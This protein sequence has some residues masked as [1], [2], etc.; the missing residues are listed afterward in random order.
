MTYF[1]F[2]VVLLILSFVGQEFL[3]AIEWAYYSRLLLVHTVFYSVAVTVP[4]PVMLLL[5]LLTGFVWDARYHIPVFPTGS[6]HSELGFGLTILLFGLMGSLIQGVRPLFRR[7]RW[8]LPVLFIGICTLAGLVIQYLII[9]FH[10]GGLYLS[11][12]MWFQMLMTSLFSMLA[13]PLILIVLSRFAKKC[14]YRI[15]LEGITRRF[16]YG[17]SL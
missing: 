13:A 7:G 3:P 4:Y 9:S 8:E 15:R 16:S 12:E 17:D 5:A 10:R 11:V 6:T 2:T 1:L 14:G